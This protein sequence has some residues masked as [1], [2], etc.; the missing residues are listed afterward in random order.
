MERKGRVFVSLIVLG[1]LFSNIT[2]CSIPVDASPFTIVTIGLPEEPQEVDVSPGSSGIVEVD[3]NVTCRKVGPDD[4]KVFLTAQSDTG[5]CSVE[6]PNLVFAGVSGTEEV[7]PFKTITR[8][9]MGYSSLETP[10]LTVS[11]YFVQGGL[12]YSVEPNS[13]MIVVLQY[14]KIRA[15]SDR[16]F[17]L[18]AYP[19]EKVRTD[20]TIFN[21]GNGEDVIL[22][23]FKNREDLENN[24][25][26]LP[27]PLEFPLQMDTNETLDLE[28]EIPQEAS[29]T[30]TV[31]GFLSSMT[32]LESENP[33]EVDFNIFLKVDELGV[34]A[35]I[36]SYFLSPISL[37]LVLIFI[38]IVVVFIR[39]Q[40]GKIADN[41]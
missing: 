29:G 4:V 6:P 17:S 26:D 36:G 37:G 39:K 13:V 16:G 38:A 23:D 1:S 41:T 9:P 34:I 19:G 31:M 20:L 11:G 27:D 22:L 18:K 8:V 35:G 32:S 21:N 28:F 24:G 15:I 3:G 14:F 33:E 2:L 7:Q 30:Y 25:F 12:Q 5:G 40:K 10:V